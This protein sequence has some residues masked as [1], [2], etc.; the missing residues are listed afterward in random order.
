MECPAC[1]TAYSA[2]QKF[3]GA[4]GHKL[5]ATCAQ[6]GSAN[7][8]HHR[9]CGQCGASLATK[10]TFTLARSGLIT[11]VDQKA[12]ELLSRD[13]N[14]LQGKP[15]SLFV[16]REDM[17]VFFSHWNELLS[18][19]RNQSFVLTLKSEEEISVSVLMSCGAA[20]PASDHTDEFRLF[21]SEIPRSRK[22]SAQLQYQQDLLGL[23]FSVTDSV[24]S[25]SNKHFDRAM[26]EALKKMCLFTKADRSFIYRINR[27]R[28]RLEP[29]YQWRRTSPSPSGGHNTLSSV[30]LTMIKRA[31]V[32][33]RRE[34]DYVVNDV[35]R[36][37]PPERYE[38]LAWHQADLG[39]IM[40]HLIYSEKLPIGIIG[41]AKDK[42]DGQWEPE[43]IAL[44]KFF[45]QLV[46]SR[47][48]FAM[49]KDRAASKLPK[50]AGSPSKAQK[51]PAADPAGSSTDLNEKR[52]G[53]RN[54]WAQIT[55]NIQRKQ[56]N[57]SP[58]ELP[59]MTRPMLIEAL[60]GHDT[61]DR[62]T[63]FPRDDGLVL[64]TCP[65]CGRQDSVSQARFDRLG[66][67]VSIHCPCRK[68]FVAV[69]EKRRALRKSVK[70]DGFFTLKG[71]LGPADATASIWGP[72]LV[73]DLS[74]TGL[75]F[76]SARA[77][78]VHPGDL[79]M[80]R[81]N[82]DNANQ[83]LI[84]KPARVI[85]SDGNAV[86]CRFEGADN[87]DITLGFYFI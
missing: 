41:M 85:S 21:L 33:L 65:R 12:L 53:A 61:V 29:A 37:A 9:F 80:V 47:L 66:K 50:E 76:S 32:R 71:D 20:V 14:E 45:A 63:V 16:K 82:L 43:C 5:E 52:S 46:S 38:L 67:A 35:A 3:C 23:M 13:H 10:G 54:S 40:C 28:K 58:S 72:I 4:C 48:P 86:G 73:E 79:I 36:L 31:I 69:L 30:P 55:P 24:C 77:G 26:A 15:F 78:L 64:L 1:Q 87:Y 60:S 19:A 39:A 83:A 17:A 25:V 27:R 11:Q 51:N 6:C 70:L 68:E 2:G 81:F 22:A 84:H 18:T 57:S 49:P 56:R 7:P 34:H 44:V 42:P 8:L 59:D 74:K 75:R 62:Q